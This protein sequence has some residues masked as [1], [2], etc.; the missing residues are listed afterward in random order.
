[1]GKERDHNFLPLHQLVMDNVL[2]MVVE[3]VAGQVS[4]ITPELE[5]GHCMA[6]GVEAGVDQRPLVML[7]MQ[8]EMEGIVLRIQ[9][10]EAEVAV[11]RGE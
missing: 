1:M 10:G 7:N 8:E 3:V 11:Q 9:L 5:E 2:N 4:T 6:V